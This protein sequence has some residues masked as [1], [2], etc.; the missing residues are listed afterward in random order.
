MMTR[1]NAVQAVGLAAV[2]FMPVAFSAWAIGC[3][4][5]TN[6]NEASCGAGTM[7]Q[8][9]VCVVIDAGQTDAQ[10]VAD[11]TTPEG[12]TEAQAPTDAPSTEATADTGVGS[13]AS[14][15]DVRDAGQYDADP[16]PVNSFTQEY[17][18]NCDPTCQ[19]Q[20]AVSQQTCQM[21]TCSAGG[22][23]SPGA[24]AQCNQILFVRPPSQP[25]TDPQ[26]SQDCPGSGW[27]YGLSMT[28]TSF[29]TGYSMTVSPPWYLIAGASAPFCPEPDAGAANCLWFDGTQG[30][31]I[32]LVTNDPMA[33]A[34]NLV[35]EC[36][37][38][39]T[40]P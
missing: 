29:G 4:S 37:A 20:E 1:R 6:N 40:C 16:C 36:A 28:F 26:C 27:T 12:S 2:G 15:V 11:G 31:V 23:W 7:L 32:Y 33:P 8:N 25:A 30:E 39:D 10:P 17:A 19:S 13:D 38:Q 22:T 24:P 35:I 5:T 9:D 21:A 18:L 3:S 34:K 14:E